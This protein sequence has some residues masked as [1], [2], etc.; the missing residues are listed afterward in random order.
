[1]NTTGAESGSTGLPSPEATGSK[2]TD[3]IPRRGL[4]PLSSLYWVPLALASFVI[5]RQV[6]GAL[7]RLV[8]WYM[9]RSSEEA[10]RWRVLDAAGL[11]RPLRLPVVMT[12]GPRWNTHAIIASVGPLPVRAHISVDR[13]VADASAQS[14]TLVVNRFPDL[15]TV[16]RLSSRD[17]RPS[18]EVHEVL[19]DDGQYNVILRYYD[20]TDQVELPPLCVD[21]EPLVIGLPVSSDTNEFYGSLGDRLRPAYAVLHYY[22]TVLLRLR[23]WL[24]EGLVFREL[25]PVG[26]PDTTFCFDAVWKGE[27]LELRADPRLLDTHIVRYTIY[28]IDSFPTQSGR[29]TRRVHLTAPS[30]R[31]GF[32]LV[33]LHRRRDGHEEVPIANLFTIGRNTEHAT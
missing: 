32:V 31:N 12:T 23:P 6:R 11:A 10:T 18:T 13:A 16:T 1:M 19:V 26:N 9:S 24:P 14:W 20:W 21:G 28:G 30:S 27:R 8:R 3:P 5:Y 22:V 17:D 25:A 2:S 4:P 29:V 15:H 7:R 33:R